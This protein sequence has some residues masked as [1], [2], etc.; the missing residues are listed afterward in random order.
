M[1]TPT[2]S[3]SARTS[4]R[5]IGPDADVTATDSSNAILIT[6]TSANVLRLVRIIGALDARE[7][8]ASDLRLVQ[9]K[10]AAASATAKLIASVFK[11][12]SAA[13]LT[14]QQA[15]QQ[16]M[17]QQQGGGGAAAA[18]HAGGTARR[19]AARSIRRC[20]AAESTPWPT[21]APTR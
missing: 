10:Y 5:S 14:P 13:P 6:D 4:R 3:S 17:M 8:A 11:A 12:E 1:P 19:T 15:Q 7:P 2:P 20:T 18:A 16:A 21:I 9:L